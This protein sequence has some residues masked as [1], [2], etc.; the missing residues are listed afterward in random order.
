[1]V[2]RVQLPGI[3]ATTVFMAWPLGSVLDRQNREVAN[4]SSL[5]EQVEFRRNLD[6][7]VAL[8][9]RRPLEL[10][11][12]LIVP[13]KSCFSRSHPN[14]PQRVYLPSGSLPIAR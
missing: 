14:P 8:T 7:P 6:A 5:A 9:T 11:V 2:K 10:F 3:N 1:M 12:M 13:I 4:R